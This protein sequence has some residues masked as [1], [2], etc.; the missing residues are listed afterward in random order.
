MGKFLLTIFFFSL[1]SQ[2]RAGKVSGT[3]TDVNGRVL[4][5]ASIIVKGSTRGAVANSQGKY[6]ITLPAGTYVFV[7]QFVGYRSEE[8]TVIVAG[9]DLVVNF[10]LSIQE[11]KMEE[12]VIRQGRDPALEIMRQTIKKRSYYKDLVDSF[13]VDGYIKGLLRSRA[14]PGKFM[15][16]K[17]DRSDMAKEGIDS[18]G[19]GILFLSESVTKVAFSRPDKIKYEVVS[20]K[21]SGGGYG[22][23]FPFFINFYVNNVSVSTTNPRGFVSP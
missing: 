9:D 1:L 23:S 12:V 15:G 21:T 17:S 16:Q 20:S 14:M 8:K 11:L 3:V 4:A 22:L 7:C 10:S 18:A 5:F 6:S 13:T 2:A 19:R